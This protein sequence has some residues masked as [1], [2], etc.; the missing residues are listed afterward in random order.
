MS[1]PY[2]KKMI[3]VAEQAAADHNIKSIRE[4]M[5]PYR[6]LL[7]KPQQNTE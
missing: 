3:A 7:L 6:V 2:N 5:L 1:E 4:S